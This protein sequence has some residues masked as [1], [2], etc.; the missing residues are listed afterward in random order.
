MREPPPLTYA[1]NKHENR[2]HIQSKLT[3][4]EYHPFIKF[5]QE[6]EFSISSALR[7]IIQT[8]PET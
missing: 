7:Y 2:F 8:H 3:Q 4:E 5:C 6:R 1:K